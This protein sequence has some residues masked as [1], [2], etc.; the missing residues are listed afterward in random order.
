MLL[1]GL[2][3]RDL[4]LEVSVSLDVDGKCSLGAQWPKW[5]TQAHES[6]A[7]RPVSRGAAMG[8]A[9]VRI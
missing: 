3:V 4:N 5:S 8:E 7:G 9:A 6:F 2:Q 1:H